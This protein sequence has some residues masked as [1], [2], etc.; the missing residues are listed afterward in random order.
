MPSQATDAVATHSVRY[1][2]PFSEDKA[3][4]LLYA[5]SQKLTEAKVS[6]TSCGRV[7]RRECVGVGLDVRVGARGGGGRSMLAMF[8]RTDE[9]R[10]RGRGH[11][12]TATRALMEDIRAQTAAADKELDTAR[13]AHTEASHAQDVCATQ[14]LIHSSPGVHSV[15]AGQCRVAVEL[16]VAVAWVL[17]AVTICTQRLNQQLGEARRKLASATAAIGKLSLGTGSITDLIAVRETTFCDVARVVMT[18]SQGA[19]GG[20]ADSPST[21]HV[22]A[23]WLGLG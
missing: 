15:P 10:R 9:R 19:E 13:A 3:N 22:L 17:L 21:A 5:L 4:T 23:N 6:V 7:E 8:L 2:T 1:D 11:M 12:Q 18:K 20:C 16:T 14:E